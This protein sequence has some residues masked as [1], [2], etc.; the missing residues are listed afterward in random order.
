MNNI[1]VE[2]VPGSFT[3]W[4]IALKR[5]TRRSSNLMA[6]LES[7]YISLF[8]ISQRVSVTPR[9]S[10]TQVAVFIWQLRQMEIFSYDLISQFTRYNNVRD[11]YR[12]VLM[13]RYGGQNWHYLKQELDKCRI[14]HQ[15]IK[16]W[17]ATILKRIKRNETFLAKKF[18]YEAFKGMLF[19]SY[20]QDIEH[21]IIFTST[22]SAATSF[23]VNAS[24]PSI[25]ISCPTWERT[26][27]ICCGANLSAT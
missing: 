27:T 2:S 22:P 25:W 20:G 7:R 26:A 10:R 23:P 21:H 19:K 8:K 17:L 15:I 24:L 3:R 12:T 11:I 16:I 14:D 5:S 9:A 13:Y 1:V 4:T 6:V 18:D